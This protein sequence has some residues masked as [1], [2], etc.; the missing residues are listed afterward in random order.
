[1]ICF[2]EKYG[3]L[4]KQQY[5]FRKERSCV[6][7]IIKI[8]DFMRNTVGK[9]CYCLALYVDFKKAFDTLT[10]LYSYIN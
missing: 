6:H 8:T 1:M 7:A 9:K 4:A 3:L 5:G 2:I 10:M